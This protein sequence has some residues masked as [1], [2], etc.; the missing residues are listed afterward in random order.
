MQFFGAYDRSA[1]IFLASRDN[2]GYAKRLSAHVKGKGLE[3]SIRHEP[4]QTQTTEWSLPYDVAFTTF[5]IGAQAGAGW[6]TA[7]DLYRQWA[8]Q[9]P[10]CQRSLSQRIQSGDIPQWLTEPSLF[11][12]FSLTGRRPDGKDGPRWALVADHAEAWRRAVGGPLTFMLMTWEKQG[13]WVAP[14]YFPPIGDGDAFRS[15]T[16][17]LHGQGHRTLV[18]LSG[19]NWTLRKTP[20]GEYP[21]I[22]NEDQFH[23]SGRAYAI[24]DLRGEPILYGQPAEDVGQYARICPTTPLADELLR[25]VALQCQDY[26]IDCVQADQLVGGGSPPCSHPDHPHPRAGGH[27]SAQALYND[28]SLARKAGK[29]KSAEF[30]FSIEEPGEFFIPLLDTYHAR[31]YMQNRWPRSGEG[32]WGVPLFTHVYHDFC[33]GYGGDSVGVSTTPSDTALYAQGMNL[34]CGKA[35]AVA[36]WSSW[37]DPATVEASQRRL[38]RSHFELWR[39]PARDYLVFGK[40]VASAPLAVPSM[41]IT[42]TD[43]PSGKHQ[44]FSVPSVL[45]TTWERSDGRRGE[46][47]ACI[48]QS[49]VT[50]LV[51]GRSLHL[52]PGEATFRELK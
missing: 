50:I 24:S 43:W 6:E 4:A 38:L 10:W 32:A 37:L 31:D 15:M 27:W 45:S 13:P 39:G 18:F 3:L 22:N 44:T 47:L 19:L 23:R 28:F 8:I 17:A 36:T 40:R 20:R 49:P 46:V 5:A 1:G 16:H 34:V 2:E 29:A 41:P 12:S 11:Y 48:S 35:P 30:A 51:A 33:L 42:F 25:A 7:A 9:Q 52:E 21:A 26:G 14:D